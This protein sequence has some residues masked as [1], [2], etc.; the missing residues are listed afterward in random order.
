[1]KLERLSDLL[2]SLCEDRISARTLLGSSA[3][4]EI[5]GTLAQGF[6]QHFQLITLMEKACDEPAGMNGRLGSKLKTDIK[7]VL[8]NDRDAIRLL[9]DIGRHGSGFCDELSSRVGAH[10]KEG[11]QDG[12]GTDWRIRDEATLTL[13]VAGQKKA[14]E[15]AKDLKKWL[16]NCE[17]LTICDPYIV[18]FS[19]PDEGK[20]T[21][22]PSI[23]E[24]VDSFPTWFPHQVVIS[25]FSG[26]VTPRRSRP[27]FSEN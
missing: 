18:H 11:R 21:L 26:A 2:K 22:F 20:V 17:K 13:I 16:R 15:A 5:C 27:R 14:K 19:V 4:L 12:L 23:D 25:N 10:E 3:F 1:M 9:Q 7:H 8:E 6:Q 24:Y